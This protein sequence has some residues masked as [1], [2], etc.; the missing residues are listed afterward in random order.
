MATFLAGILGIFVE[1]IRTENTD[2]IMLVLLI[3][4]LANYKKQIII[5]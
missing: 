2:D 1:K 3:F 4:S 5:F